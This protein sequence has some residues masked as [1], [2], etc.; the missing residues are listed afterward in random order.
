LSHDTIQFEYRVF[1]EDTDPPTHK[2]L[3]SLIKAHYPNS[4]VS[5]EIIN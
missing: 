1:I 3:E 2:E 4:N 5:A